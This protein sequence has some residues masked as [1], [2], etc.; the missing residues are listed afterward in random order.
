M[1]FNFA[2]HF[3]QFDYHFKEI[4]SFICSFYMGQ[5]FVGSWMSFGIYLDVST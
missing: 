4:L 3:V 1:R 2:L 5:I